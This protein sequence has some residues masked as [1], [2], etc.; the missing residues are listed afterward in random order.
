MAKEF[1]VLKEQAN[2][3]KN[4]VEDGA[5]TASRVG[6]M[7]EDI[8]D[9]MQSGVTEVNVSQL[10]PTGGTGGSNKYTLETAIAKVG[11]E[12]RHAGLK[13]TFLN[14]EGTTETWEF[15]GGTFTNAGSWTQCGAKILTE[16]GNNFYIKNSG[17]SFIKELYI[18]GENIKDYHDLYVSSL[19]RNSNGTW[20]FSIKGKNY[21]EDVIVLCN[22]STNK[23]DNGIIT[24]PKNSTSIDIQAYVIII[25]DNVKLG[26]NGYDINLPLTNIAFDLDYSPSIK[27]YLLAKDVDKNKSDISLLKSEDKNISNKIVNSVNG[28]FLTSD[29]PFLKELYVFGQ[30]LSLYHDLFIGGLKRNASNT[31]Q[32][33]VKGKDSS[34]SVQVLCTY[35]KQKEENGVITLVG[36]SS[37]KV[38]AFAVLYWDNVQDGLN[39]WNVNY[40]LSNNAFNL[41]YS[42]S[43]KSYLLGESKQ[44]K[45]VSAVNIKTLN[46]Q[47]LLGDGDITIKSGEIN[48]N[49][50]YCSI[51]IYHNYQVFKELFLRE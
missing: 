3:I 29:I 44:E 34:E 27:E 49:N 22:Y 13:V 15:Q 16:L 14:G 1:D 26:F 9:R 30:D 40:P 46:G 21:N 19:K 43:I 23:E 35:Q 24:V 11:E 41:D 8:V 4:E 28:F 20:Q 7:F 38:S 37:K 45:L 10:Y 42:P 12:L 47:S 36:D 2:V 25:W 18:Y 32:L 50:L 31:W 51:Q 39:G 48:F 33:T 6:G 5:N 17:F